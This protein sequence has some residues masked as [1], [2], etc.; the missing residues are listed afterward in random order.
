MKNANQILKDIK[1]SL[2][3]DTVEET[4]EVVK[5]EVVEVEMATEE[6]T[7]DEVT[8]LAEEEAKE[9]V[10]EEKVAVSFATEEQLSNLRVELLSMIKAIIEDK[11]EK[12]DKDVPQ[13]LAEQVELAEE[14]VEEIV[15]SPEATVDKSNNYN[16]KNVS[17]MSTSERIRARLNK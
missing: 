10:V 17:Q 4:V 15:H 1:V 7:K 14:T 2:G 6:E 9:E 3:I 13:E 5:E 8:E 16:F 12:E 11:S